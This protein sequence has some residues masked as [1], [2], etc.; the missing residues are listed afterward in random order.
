MDARAWSISELVPAFKEPQG[1][2]H[3]TQPAPEFR[4][5]LV[6]S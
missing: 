2:H 4:S 3:H 1:Y 6:T 5:D